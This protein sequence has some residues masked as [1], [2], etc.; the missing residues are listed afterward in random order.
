M[1]TG[2]YAKRGLLQRLEYLLTLCQASR[3]HAVSTPSCGISSSS[4]PV[5]S[6]HTLLSCLPGVTITQCL[7]ELSSTR[8]F[9]GVTQGYSSYIEYVVI[10]KYWVSRTQSLR[11]VATRAFLHALNDFYAMRLVLTELN[12]SRCHW[13][14]LQQ[15]V[16]MSLQKSIQGDFEGIMYCNN[17][18]SNRYYL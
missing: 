6:T 16:S 10:R 9:L 11:Y 17:A 8:I 15:L 13:L 7:R 12:V 18:T 1:N 5:L 4:M 3:S 14:P 2:F